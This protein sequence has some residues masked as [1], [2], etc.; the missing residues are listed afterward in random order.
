VL[1]VG[2]GPGRIRMIFADESWV[3]VR[4]GSGTTIFSRLNAPGTERVVRGLPPFDVVVGNAHRVRLLYEDK[5]IDLGPHT[6]VDVAR[7]TL[8]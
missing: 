5:P 8:E 4:D 7:I 2:S 1:V 6:R 3:E